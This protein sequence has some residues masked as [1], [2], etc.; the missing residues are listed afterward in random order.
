MLL[1]FTAVVQSKV[2]KW[3]QE[4]IEL[5]YDSSSV[6]QNGQNQESE[7]N[8][9]KLLEILWAQFLHPIIKFYQ[10]QHAELLSLL[11]QSTKNHKND[12]KPVEMRKLNE[13]FIKFLKCVVS[14]YRKTLEYVMNTYPNPVITESLFQDLE[15]EMNLKETPPPSTDFIANTMLVL[16]Q[17]LLGLG[18][19]TRHSAHIQINYVEPSKSYT[20]YQ[21]YAKRTADPKAKKAYVKPLLYYSKCIQ[22]FPQM[23]EPYNHIGVIY[24]SL[25]DK[26]SAVV[27]FLRSQFT[28]DQNK[29][30]GKYN[31]ATIFRKPWLEQNYTLALK[32]QS[33][34][35]STQD[36]QV[37]LLRIMGH[38]FYPEAFK[39]PLYCDKTSVD[40]ITSTFFHSTPRSFVRDA[41]N[42]TDTLTIMMCFY[43]IAET[44]E[45]GEARTKCGSL[46]HRFIINYL[47]HVARWSPET[48]DDSGILKNIRFIL[49][50]CSDLPSILNFGKDDVVLALYGTISSF[51][52]TDEETKANIL[53]AFRQAKKPFRCYLFP[54]DVK[55]K[56]FL[57]IGFKFHDFDD[58]HLL[59]SGNVNLLLGTPLNNLEVIPSFLD[60]A[61]VQ[62]I[63]KDLELDGRNRQ[64]AIMDEC[65][66]LENALR[67]QA[68]VISCK[69]LFP[70]RFTVDGE[71]EALILEKV[72]VPATQSQKNNVSM[73]KDKD[74]ASKKD[75]TRKKKKQVPGV[76]PPVMS[77]ASSQKKVAASLDEIE[78]MILGHV[79]VF[80]SKPSDARDKESKDRNV[81]DISTEGGLA[82]MVNAILSEEDEDKTV[83]EKSAATPEEDV[84]VLHAQPKQQTSYLPPIQAYQMP[85]QMPPQPIIAAGIPAA[86]P[87][88][89]Y[90][91]GYYPP[92]YPYY[93]Q[94]HQGQGQVGMRQ[95][96]QTR[97]VRHGQMGQMAPHV[98]PLPPVGPVPPQG[99]QMYPQWQ[100]GAPNGGAPNGGA[101]GQYRQYRQ[102]PQ[103]QG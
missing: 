98:G 9:V 83:S 4:D 25:N 11:L 49:A 77:V 97:P 72:D 5:L 93:Y 75:K 66:R 59:K 89:G 14:F 32:K 40:F 41:D 17:C 69:H 63:N 18:N 6:P 50:F 85:L 62:R 92:G 61:A 78:L 20:H 90:Q 36:L 102:Y 88:F 51:L 100:Y 3:I 103:Y 2:Y 87:G 37:I 23:C 86:Q 96:S 12:F 31:M 21:N 8:L 91:Q 48:R 46:L 74:G 71:R 19:I 26:P 29:T 94:G 76:N 30:I 80:K 22:L 82:D 7:F 54:E 42:I 53:V 10:R 15:I 73:K 16:Y 95:M 60:N 45:L 27:W 57:P 81:R 38:I 99:P 47:K 70:D 101:S 39:K 28:L 1:G 44:E 64:R 24:N 34:D 13:F 68:I 84:K 56:Q 79:S 58:G 43:R 65:T 35:L 52:D 55:F 67:L 33:A